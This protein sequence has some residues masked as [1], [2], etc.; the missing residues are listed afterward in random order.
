M[1]PPPFFIVG[2]QRSGTTLLRV[3]L[4][5]H[6]E[7]AI[8][9]DTVGLWS[10]Y[11]DRL[12]ADYHDLR[13]ADDLRRL[14]A[15]LMAEERIRLWDV[16]L[17]ADRIIAEVGAERSLARVMDAMHRAYAAAKGKSRWGD[18]DPGNMT[19]MHRIHQW[20]PEGQFL[21]IIRDGRDACLSHLGVDFGY[22]DV[23]PCA[24]EWREVVEWVRRIGA[25]LGPQRYLE[26]KYEDLV[27]QPEDQLRRVCA[28]LH[29]DYSPQMLEYHRRVETS[30]PDS[31]RHIWPKI[32]Q[33]PRADNTEQW[34]QKMSAG[35]LVCFEKRAGRLLRELGYEVT[36][37]PWSGA[38]LTE[39]GSMARG[40]WAAV[41]RRVR[42]A[43]KL[44][45]GRSA[46][47]SQR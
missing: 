46:K 41:R 44:T 1:T 2:F 16:P 29:A 26:V 17:D 6:P 11:D 8:P 34:K 32:G 30:I 38:Y 7:I 10:R 43:L 25:V 24:C 28:F 15:D 39:V 22:D 5:N 9:L 18:K 42:R 4:D 36:P 20:F 13:T 19:Q 23:L 37:G 47:G 33:P 3:M 40:T 31:K 14:V 21:H 35:Q 12:A 45:G 27:K